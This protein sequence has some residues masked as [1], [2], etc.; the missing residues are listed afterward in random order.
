MLDIDVKQKEKKRKKNGF[1][2]LRYKISS[3]KYL[4]LKKYKKNVDLMLL[5]IKH[6]RIDEFLPQS[7][8]VGRGAGFT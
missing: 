7:G 3:N 6:L 5:Y 2:Y 8:L 1:L 4:S